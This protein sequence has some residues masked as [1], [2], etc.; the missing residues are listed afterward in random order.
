MQKLVNAIE[1]NP[2]KRWKNADFQ[3]L[4]IDAVT[5]RRQFKKDLV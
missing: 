5:A 3:A 1:E 2:E 4:S